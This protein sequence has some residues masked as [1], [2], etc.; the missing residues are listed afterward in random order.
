MEV[1]PETL[2]AVFGHA[3]SSVPAERDGATNTLAQAE[4]APGFLKALFQ[5]VSEGKAE[6]VIRLGA[7]IHFK[8]QVKKRWLPSADDSRTYSEEEK[9]LVRSALF[10]S[11]SVAQP[12]RGQVL[13]S[14]RLVAER[15]FP[16]N[17]PGVTEQIL[18]GLR[19]DDTDQTHCA[20]LALRKLFKLFENRPVNRRQ[21]LEALVVATDPTLQILAPALIQ[22]AAQPAPQSTVAFTMLKI[23]L[24]CFHS[25][26]YMG[27]GA[28]LRGN[29][30]IWMQLVLKASELQCL[31]PMPSDTEG[32]ETS[33]FAKCQ[34]W[35]F[36]ILLRFTCRHGNSR[37]AMDGMEGFAT[38]WNSKYRVP[39]TEVC[40]K[41]ACSQGSIGTRARNLALLC[42]AD[43][44]A[45]DGAF[46]AMRPQLQ[47]LL[48]LGIFSAAR[49]NDGD[50]D[51]WRN[52]PD[53]YLR[54]FFDDFGAF[55]DPRAAAVDLVERLVQARED[56]VLQP[57]L[58]FCRQHLDAQK[59]NPDDKALC[60]NKDGALVL[61]SALGDC[62]LRV[63]PAQRKKKKAAKPRGDSGVSVEAL[64]SNY[65]FQDFNNSAA[66]LRLRAC[67][68]YSIFAQ[69]GVKF[70][71]EGVRAAACKECMRLMTDS[72][73]PVRVVAAVSLQGLIGN[74]DQ[75]I[76]SAVVENMGSLLICLL[77]ILSEVQVEE[78]AETLENIVGTFPD[79]IVPFAVQLVEHLSQT[80]VNSS[81]AGDDDDE[82]AGTA[83]GSMQAIISI[84][85]S[86]T[87]GEASPQEPRADVFAKL[88]VVLTPLLAGQILRP[89]GYDFLEEG[90]EALAYLTYYSPSPL[91]PVLWNLFPLLFQSVC[92]HSTPSLPLE[93]FAANGWAADHM[94]NMLPVLDNFVSRGPVEVFLSGSWPEAAM[95]YPDMLFQAV[96]K[97]VQLEGLG[98]ERNCASAVQVAI[99]FI[100]NIPGTVCAVWL[101]R[102]F[103]LLWKRLPTTQTAQLRRTVLTAFATF[104]WKDA[105]L[106]LRCTEEKACTQQL[107]EGW[108]QNVALFKGLRGKKV[109]M[110]SLSRL[111][112]LS[113]SQSI[114]SCVASGLPLM[115]R[116]LAESTTEVIRLRKVTAEGGEVE[117]DDDDDEDD[118]RVMERALK[119]LQ[120]HADSDEDIND[121]D[122]E[123][124]AAE[125]EAGGATLMEKRSPLDNVDE[126]Q[127][128]L[129]VLQQA[130]TGLQQQIEGWLG[131]G[132]GTRW[133]AELDAE[134]QRAV[135]AS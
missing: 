43:S 66:F 129:G 15:D 86:C 107:F 102:Y 42:L 44:C 10:N 134:R 49:F 62:L 124:S 64:L 46:G 9:A 50:A 98:E 68:V 60:A 67:S 108:L 122:D 57:L 80:V 89:S 37:R 82:G 118:E 40:L 104:V 91:P 112:Q 2:Y 116:T 4:G 99:A 72:E 20:L 18:S 88:S 93:D 19:S 119:K 56:E 65:V 32:R 48:E 121:D 59:Q 128:L 97:V 106:F 63:D 39:V 74:A 36:Y 87:G 111:V 94:V 25:A 41:A 51:T 61:I 17:W 21:E 81:G 127:A 77:K 120:N 130:P 54:V 8:N 52:D 14:F 125:D 101:P 58:A 83:M 100:E 70:S 5:I 71:A 69:K 75:E 78:V 11:I 109:L 135:A 133:V 30:D 22:A 27:L 16:N 113:C 123:D 76:R 7:A 12:V 29:T 85:E 105:V 1:N 131:A 23:V 132:A 6:P 115:V 45:D 95:T 117:S 114:P 31:Q 73:K 33:S 34:K 28:H 35:V 84:L 110:L 3:L 92:G 90:L 53:E 126:I 13:E 47:Q 79:E 24:K 26:T 103:D 96:A 38:E 55:S